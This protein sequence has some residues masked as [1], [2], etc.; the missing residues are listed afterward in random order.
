M[1]KNK[2]LLISFPL[3]ITPALIVSSCNTTEKKED[4]KL[5]IDKRLESMTS[6]VSK[7]KNIEKLNVLYKSL[8]T[9][10][11]DF[12]EKSQSKN[13]QTGDFLN[14]VIVAQET[15]IN[16]IVEAIVDL[17]KNN[18]NSDEAKQLADAKKTIEELKNNLEKANEKT[19][20]LANELKMVTIE[21][22]KFSAKESA[23]ILLDFINKDVIDK[24][25]TNHVDIY[26]TDKESL[27]KLLNQANQYYDL[28]KDK[29]EDYTNMIN[30][31]NSILGLINLVDAYSKYFVGQNAL[32]SSKSEDFMNE[33]FNWRLSQ[34]DMA[35]ELV[36]KLPDT[37]ANKA[38]YLT[39]ISASK[40]RYT[41][42]KNAIKHFVDQLITF[43]KLEKEEIFKYVLAPG[44]SRYFRFEYIPG[45]SKSPYMT[46]Y[47][48]IVDA[49]KIEEF[50]DISKDIEN[51]FNNFL[52]NNQQIKSL[53]YY[54]D[55]KKYFEKSFGLLKNVEYVT[56]VKTTKEFRYELEKIKDNLVI[57]EKINFADDNNKLS[58][59]INEFTTK[60]K[61]NSIEDF[62][63]TKIKPNKDKNSAYIKF[64]NESTQT[65]SAVKSLDESNFVSKFHKFLKLKELHERLITTN[66]LFKFYEVLM[67]E[68]PKTGTVA[69]LIGL[70]KSVAEITN[71]VTKNKAQ[72][73][74][75]I[76]AEEFVLNETNKLLFT[77]V[78]TTAEKLD[79][80]F[81]KVKADMKTFELNV[82]AEIV[83][84]KKLDPVLIS[85]ESS[86]K[87]LTDFNNLFKS[88]IDTLC[89]QGITS[90]E[91]DAKKAKFDLVK[92]ELDEF[93]KIVG[94][95][96]QGQR[97]HVFEILNQ[98]FKENQIQLDSEEAKESI[99]LIKN[100]KEFINQS[101]NDFT[102][103]DVVKT[104]LETQKTKLDSL[105]QK[106]TEGE[107]TF[108]SVATS[109]NFDAI[110][111]LKKVLNSYK[112]E[113]LKA[114]DKRN[115]ELNVQKP[116]LDVLVASTRKLLPEFGTIEDIDNL[117]IAKNM[118]IK[119][120]DLKKETKTL[121]DSIPKLKETLT[122]VPLQEI[123][124]L[125]RNTYPNLEAILNK[126][127]EKD[128]E[129]D[130]ISR[131]ILF[132]DFMNNQKTKIESLKLLNKI[133][134]I[135]ILDP[136]KGYNQQQA[137]DKIN[138]LEKKYS[139]LL[140]YHFELVNTNSAQS[141]LDDS[142]TKIVQA[143]VEYYKF[144]NSDFI[145]IDKKSA[146]RF[147]LANFLNEDFSDNIPYFFADLLGRI[148]G[149][150][151]VS[152]FVLKEYFE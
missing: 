45:I 133:E 107:S 77:P 57:L 22:S 50:K 65:Y 33:M 38:K 11:N 135:K 141:L 37:N 130:M 30:F 35:S 125:I 15:Q 136:S 81:A 102:S 122:I 8:N 85:K 151:D 70:T 20:K 44:S 10:I 89:D 93:V 90:T 13:N 56:D 40:T 19:E 21:L 32:T 142:K 24:L 105:E 104:Y 31:E 69:D 100:I 86:N 96:D 110:T 116:L 18:N 114:Y 121:E 138:E 14:L 78:D 144:L 16:K 71:L 34:F 111:P 51:T 26:N 97:I 88:K 145:E 67:N 92:K 124:I 55:Y 60:T 1:K 28:I 25:K 2:L 62:I 94:S 27:G 126:M 41:E 140:R 73:A 134:D 74:K 23:K 139:E 52:K 99:A 29:D 9:E 115:D 5:K 75:I 82:K 123:L 6:A 48:H 91:L 84:D 98:S 72:I 87:L 76:D 64:F 83:K 7:I 146:I 101:K 54:M 128:F 36:K 61:K 68:D 66:N 143:R 103:K 106:I 80:F 149:R 17:S 150:N 59:K 119:I 3:A 39:D 79:A 108:F 109:T 127:F 148:D 43:E 58:D 49:K 129:Q 42:Q 120:Y 47:K 46:I 117:F 152:N 131:E 147:D 95:K 4:I 137:F 118:G 113:L 132:S 53:Y 63:E 112:V 12:K